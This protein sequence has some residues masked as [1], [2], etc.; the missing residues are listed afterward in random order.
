MVVGY[1]MLP[2]GDCGTRLVHKDS[3]NVCI[4]SDR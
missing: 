3:R 4:F 2:G 1:G